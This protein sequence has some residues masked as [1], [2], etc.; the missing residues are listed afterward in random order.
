MVYVTN[1]SSGSITILA[2]EQTQ[3][4]PLTTT[5]AP[6]AGNTTTSQTPTF[7]F[8]ATNNFNPFA[9]AALPVQG[10]FFQLDSWQGPWTAATPN[11][12]APG[13]SGTAPTLVPGTHTLFAYATDG[14]DSSTTHTGGNGIGESSPLIGSI[15]AYTFTVTDSTGPE[16]LL[17]FAEIDFGDVPVGSPS[18]ARVVIVTNTGLSDLVFTSAGP[19]GG[20]NPGDFDEQNTCF[21]EG[22]LP[23]TETCTIVVAFIPTATGPRS[24]TLSLVDNAANSP[25]TVTFTGI[26]VAAVVPI[27]Q[28]SST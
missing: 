28:L 9:P 25:Q 19:A 14:E 21:A 2:E 17:S 20:A 26:G 24:A 8:T 15:A 6:L 3:S 27:A 23:P 12:T 7:K 5:I 16:V 10:V 18:D 22:T 13:F 4:I 1:S 11:L